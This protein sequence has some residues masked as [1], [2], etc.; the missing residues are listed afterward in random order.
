MTSYRPDL[1]IRLNVDL[2]T[3]CARKPAHDRESLARKIAS[4]PLLLF[5]GAHIVAIDANLPLAEVL[6]LS[7]AAAATLL[8]VTGLASTRVRPAPPPDPNTIDRTSDT[9]G[10]G[11]D[12]R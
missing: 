2:N 6:A 10:R 11:S 8:A 1:V 4:T 5:H 12:E 9:R 3:A 7:M